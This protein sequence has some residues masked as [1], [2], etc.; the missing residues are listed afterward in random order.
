MLKSTLLDLKIK[1]K[2]NTNRNHIQNESFRKNK[3]LIKVTQV[4]TLKEYPSS[5]LVK[6]LE[7][8]VAFISVYFCPI[9]ML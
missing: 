2:Q 8:C 1:M 6:L 3:D 4:Q 5:T 7:L 9:S